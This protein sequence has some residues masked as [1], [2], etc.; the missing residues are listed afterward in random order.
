MGDGLRV[1]LE[2]D[3]EGRRGICMETM[4]SAGMHFFFKENRKSLTLLRGKKRRGEEG[5]EEEKEGKEKRKEEKRE[6]RREEGNTK[7]ILN[8]EV[9]PKEVI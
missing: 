3:V 2:I 5:R 6:G 1:G 7:R 9:C 4:G 8:L